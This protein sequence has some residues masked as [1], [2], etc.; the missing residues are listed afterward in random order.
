VTVY[1]DELYF[2]WLYAQVCSVRLKNPS[3]THRNLLSLLFDKDFVWF[4]PNDDNR[5][6]DGRDL[7]IE[8]LEENEIQ[9]GDDIWLRGNCSVLEV[10]IGI[11]RRL[12]FETGRESQDWFWEL[13]ENLDLRHYNDRAHI[14]RD[15]IEDILNRVIFRTYSYD[16]RGGLFPLERAD[17]DQRE[18]EIW[19]QISAYVLERNYI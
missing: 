2:E 10:F 12:E 15:R 5:I 17:R 8:F 9:L 1:L 18:T 16:G 19:Y 14:P 3:R 7:R 13:M 4:V 6:E 11:C